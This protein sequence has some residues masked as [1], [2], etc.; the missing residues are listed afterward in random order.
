VARDEDLDLLKAIRLCA[1]HSVKKRDADYTLRFVFRWYSEKFHTPLH[2]VEEIPL[3]IL[4]E[5]YFEC[6][7]ESLSEHELEEEIERL[8]ETHAERLAREKKE[9]EDAAADEAFLKMHQDKAR[10]DEAK[11]NLD[12]KLDLQ[13]QAL[14]LPPIMGDGQL[15]PSFAQVAAKADPNLNKIPTAP[16]SINM[17]FVSDEE[18]EGLGDWDLL[19]APKGKK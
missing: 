16:P 17:S 3:E 1:V 11:T 9:A 4:M 15:P 12:K 2:E 18:M 5:H 14:P 8:A 13:E 10:V 19:G 6:H 7:Y